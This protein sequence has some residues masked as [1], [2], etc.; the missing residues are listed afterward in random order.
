M[1]RSY[2]Y[3]YNVENEKIKRETIKIEE[4]EYTETIFKHW[5]KIKIEGNIEAK[6]RGEKVLR[7]IEK[8]IEK[9]L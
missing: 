1:G 4:K 7:K 5:D 8:L 3:I 6:R 2:I 9:Y